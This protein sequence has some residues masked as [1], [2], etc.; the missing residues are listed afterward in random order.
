MIPRPSSIPMLRHINLTA[1]I[2]FVV[3]SAGCAKPVPKVA[4]PAEGRRT[5]LA[6]Q[7]EEGV[8]VV[9]AYLRCRCH[10]SRP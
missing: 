10:R 8:E 9:G 7:I 1:L 4:K 6:A 2:L 5:R 3:V